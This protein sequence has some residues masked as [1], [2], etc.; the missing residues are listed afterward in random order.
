ME[1]RPRFS[2][3][4]AGDTVCKKIIALGVEQNFEMFLNQ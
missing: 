1:P 3:G 4:P 2:Q